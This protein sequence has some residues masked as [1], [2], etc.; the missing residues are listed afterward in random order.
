MNYIQKAWLNV[1]R[2]VTYVLNDK[3]AKRSGWIGRFGR[4]FST[5]PREFGYHPTNRLLAFLNH[6]LM[7]TIGF[8]VHRYSVLKSLTTNGFHL[9]RI[10]RLAGLA[11][12]PF[13]LMWFTVLPYAMMN[14]I[15]DEVE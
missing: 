6:T 13:V 11:Y 8:W 15:I 9:S 10:F 5:G 7:E 12:V 4:F 1:L 14:R 2:P 3:L